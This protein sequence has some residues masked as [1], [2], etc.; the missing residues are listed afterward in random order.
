MNTA[1]HA[2]QASFAAALLDPDAAQRLGSLAPA[3]RS[4]AE[5]EF[6]L[7]QDPLRS[8]PVNERLVSHLARSAYAYLRLGGS[9][10]DA[11]GVWVRYGE[12]L[13]VRAVGEGTALRTEFWDYGTG[14]AV[15]FRRPATSTVHSPPSS[16]ARS[17]VAPCPSIIARPTAP[18]SVCPYDA[19]RR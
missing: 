12:P 4:Q 7:T 1:L 17:T 8:T 6:W 14:P 10:T 18:P 3:V 9:Q 15:M 19:A 16:Q 13:R 2:L 11:G 5:D